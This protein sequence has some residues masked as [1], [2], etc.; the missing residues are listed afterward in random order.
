MNPGFRHGVW[1]ASVLVSGLVG[2]AESG[3]PPTMPGRVLQTLTIS[4][5]SDDLSLGESRQLRAEAVF[6]NGDRDDVTSAARWSSRTL[7]CAVTA[8]GLVTAVEIGECAIDVAYAGATGTVLV[9]VRPSKTYVIT[10]VV[11]EKWGFREPPIPG[12]SVALVSGGQ[13]GR[14]TTTDGA[15][16][17]VFTGVPAE[18]VRARAEAAGYEPT[19]VNLSPDHPEADLLVSPPFDTL[20]W[21]AASDTYPG[22]PSPAEFSFQIGHRGPVT[23]TV[24]STHSEC[25]SSIDFVAYVKP[26]G[27]EQVVVYAPGSCQG[28][29]PRTAEAILDAGRYELYIWW[30]AFYAVGQARSVDMNYPR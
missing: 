30:N 29:V 20:S 16:R 4:G 28:R 26:E 25:D 24:L 6:S 15:G 8:S 17:Y 19:E 2:C 12:A 3:R 22:P 1:V 23:L 10:G 18:A 9:G 11:R 7:T 5:L 21:S 27:T 14:T 13:A